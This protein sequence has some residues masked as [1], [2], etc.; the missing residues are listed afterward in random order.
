[1]ELYKTIDLEEIYGE[2]AKLVELPVYIAKVMTAAGFGQHVVLTGAAPV[3]MYLACAH[4]L[5]G[6]ARSLGYTSPESG[7]VSIFNHD[8]R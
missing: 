6:I 3:W 5:H 2:T 4:S 7:L 1:M 8:P